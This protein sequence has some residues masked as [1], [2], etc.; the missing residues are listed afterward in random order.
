MFPVL[1]NMHVTLH[2]KSE[3]ETQQHDISSI[4]L[5]CGKTHAFLSR[6]RESEENFSPRELYV[7]F[8]P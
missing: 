4:V 5:S 3:L 2:F 7:A 1:L 8:A 6:K